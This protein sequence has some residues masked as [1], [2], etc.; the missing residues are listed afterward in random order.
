MSLQIIL[1]LSAGIFFLCLFYRL[2]VLCG[3]AIIRFQQLK[4]NTLALHAFHA[5]C[6]QQLDGSGG[7]VCLN[8]VVKAVVIRRPACKAAV[9]D[10]TGIIDMRKA[11]HQE[12]AEFESEALVNRQALQF[13]KHM[14]LAELANAIGMAYTVAGGIQ[15]FNS[16]GASDDAFACF[17]GLALSMI[18]TLAG[19][20]ISIPT[21]EILNAYGARIETF[22]RQVNELTMYWSR[23]L[24]AAD[25]STKRANIAR[26]KRV[27]GSRGEDEAL[28]LD[29]HLQSPQPNG[30]EAVSDAKT[31]RLPDGP[32]PVAQSNG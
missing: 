12:A 27:P 6:E 30:R 21:R 16:I 11:N 25:H 24:N 18:T 19:L 8:Q 26:R 28:C 32:Q 3:S 1:N 17:P 23:V 31:T 10:L 22:E 7:K 14:Q 29:I 20:A 9:K 15:V 5:A 13:T 4:T 2:S